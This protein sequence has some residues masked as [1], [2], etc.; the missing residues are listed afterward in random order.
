MWIRGGAT[1]SLPGTPTE[2]MVSDDRD[3]NSTGFEAS[4]LHSPPGSPRPILQLRGGSGSSPRS[5]PV[6]TQHQYLRSRSTQAE[7][8]E[9]STQRQWSRPTETERQSGEMSQRPS[10]RNIGSRLSVDLNKYF[11]LTETPKP[12]RVLIYRFINPHKKCSSPHA[13]LRALLWVLMFLLLLG[14]LFQQWAIVA[15]TEEIKQ[16]WAKPNMVVVRDWLADRRPRAAGWCE[17]DVC[18]CEEWWWVRI[19][20][21]WLLEWLGLDKKFY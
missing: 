10:T 11:T 15:H 14:S 5:R 18:Y 16:Q 17:D 1:P 4:N 21:E 7:L 8:D 3:G 12:R 20:R 6:I 9:S 19:V 2:E 13:W